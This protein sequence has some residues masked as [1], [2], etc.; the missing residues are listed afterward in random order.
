MGVPLLKDRARILVA[1]FETRTASALVS[2]L[3]SESFAAQEHRRRAT[4]LAR[5]SVYRPDVLLL[6]LSDSDEASSAPLITQCQRAAPGARVVLLASDVPNSKDVL[7]AL[8][9][10]VVMLVAPSSDEVLAAI[11]GLVSSEDEL[12]L[13]VGDTFREVRPEFLQGAMI[14][15][16][17]AISDGGGLKTVADAMGIS[18]RT[19]SR[20]ARRLALASPREILEAVTFL[21]AYA[22]ATRAGAELPADVLL[23]ASDSALSQHGRKSRVL[24]PL[25][26]AIEFRVR[27]LGGSVG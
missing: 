19:L 26:R 7:L 6:P 24:A 17:N 13:P 11:D 23:S 22:I 2:A 18:M 8:R 25:R 16:W 12:A 3:R 4:L 15:M 10:D 20:E 9:H 14:A 1:L 21:H 27:S 5:L